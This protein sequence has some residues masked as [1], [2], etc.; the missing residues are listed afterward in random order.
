MVLKANMPKNGG[1]IM[2]N[3]SVINAIKVLTTIDCETLLELYPN[4]SKNINAPTGI[5]PTNLRKSIYMV[6]KDSDEMNGQAS[7]ELNIKADQGDTIHWR[8]TSLSL[9]SDLSAEFY[10]FRYTGGNRNVIT[11]PFHV[12]NGYWLANVIVNQGFITYDWKF[13]ILDRRGQVLGYFYWDPKI[14]VVS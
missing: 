14:T 10:E 5:N 12:G 6:T 2:S 8:A 1:K 9:D 3:G 13:K 7:P 4:A 11:P